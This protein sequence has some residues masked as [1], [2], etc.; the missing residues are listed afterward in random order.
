M[1]S[2]SHEYFRCGVMTVNIVDKMGSLVSIETS[3]SCGCRGILTSDGKM[4]YLCQGHGGRHWQV[5]Y[6]DVALGSA[7]RCCGCG[8]VHIRTLD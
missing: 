2:N 6:P 5:E 7:L 1:C 3:E 8:A 4:E